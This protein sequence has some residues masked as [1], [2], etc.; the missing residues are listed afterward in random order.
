ML[1]YYTHEI[2]QTILLTRWT[3]SVKHSFAHE[4][5]AAATFNIFEGVLQLKLSSDI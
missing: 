5:R 2:R 4:L 3:S 1:L